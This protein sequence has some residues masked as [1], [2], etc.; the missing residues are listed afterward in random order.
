M[1]RIFRTVVTVMTIMMV[2]VACN[3]KI[4]P[5][6]QQELTP[7]QKALEKAQKYLRDEIF[8]N[9]Y[10]W[11]EQMNKAA[12][13]YK[14]NLYKYFDKLLVKKDRWSW[15][16][17][18]PSYV[19][20]ESGVVYGSYGISLGQVIDPEDSEETVDYNVYVRFVYPD[21]PFEEAGVRRGWTLS[22]LDDKSVLN[23]WLSTEEYLDQF[24]DIIGYPSTTEAHKFGFADEEGKLHSFTVTAAESLS[25][26]PCLVK[27]I[28]TAEDYPGL[29]EPVGYFNYLSFKADEDVNGKTML[30][31]ITEPMAYFKENGVKTLI[32]D[33]RYNGGG[34]SR[35]SDLLVSY[36]APAS[37]R[38]KVYVK[39]IHNK[40]LSSENLSSR[41]K[42]P[43]AAIQ[44]LEK[45]YKVNFSSKPDSPEFEHLYFI[46][47]KG[48]ASAS[49]MCLNGLKPLADVHHVG[50]ITY[51]KP[52]GMYVFMYPYTSK[53]IKAYDQGDY[54]SLEYVFL[55][56]CFYNMNGDGVEI[57]E[58][59][60][61][62]DAI[63]ADDLHHDF[64]AEESNIA[65]CLY[66]IVN[67]SYP[68][69]ATTKSITS[70]QKKIGLR[71]TITPE[72][73]NDNY[74]LYTVKP[75]FL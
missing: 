5:D 71:A 40:A 44:D 53:D 7:E 6:T 75:D 68:A 14:T 27:D 49:E 4:N 54:S 41:V 43:K 9:Y 45:N 55:P 58:N 10:Y 25:I 11:N 13:S 3:E 35:A 30:D 42:S 34:D 16:M 37:A 38:D 36:L 26:R 20:D 1:K 32:V 64:C 63:L 56:I 48:S 73:I 21:S 8:E 57:P 28:F 52:N 12:C 51:G 74:G 50:G 33:L 69:K 61:V 18:G 39:R 19:A 17:D 24:N 46:T 66:H 65:A 67:G 62:P 2:A 29:T 31:D 22:Y 59:G 72:E 47:G 60:M 70:G 15:M 23:Y